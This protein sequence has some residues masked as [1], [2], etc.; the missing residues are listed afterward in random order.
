MRII[1]RIV[2]AREAEEIPSIE[3]LQREREH[4]EKLFADRINFYI[5]FAAGVLV[6]LLDRKPPA[7]IEKAA[8]WT[9]VFVSVLM[10]FALIR[11][12]LLVRLVLDEIMEY[13]EDAPYSRYHE[14]L[15]YFIPN[16]NYFLLGLPL[17]LTGFFIYALWHI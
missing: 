3:V 5:V 1:W 17:A 4:L 14:A 8:L 16:A 9:V 15:K 12:L 7:P 10:L 11:T 13:Y 6:F 2:L